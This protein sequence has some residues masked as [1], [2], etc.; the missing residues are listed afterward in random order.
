MLERRPVAELFTRTGARK[1]K[2]KLLVPAAVLVLAQGC[3]TIMQGSKEQVSISSNPTGAAVFV[4]GQQL[5]VTPMVAQLARKGNHIVSIQLDG[6]KPY[7]IAL[8]KSVSGWVA[9]NLVFGGIPG[10]VVD[11]ITGGM[12][13]LSPTQVSATLGEMAFIEGGDGIAVAVVLGADPAWEKIGQMEA[14]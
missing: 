7:E 1:V 10:L 12:Y 2:R 4:D 13:K 8:N 11:A 5:G 6:Y 14:E 9:G 3:A